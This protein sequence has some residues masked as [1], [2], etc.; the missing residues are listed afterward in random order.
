MEYDPLPLRV[1]MFLVHKVPT[2]RTAPGGTWVADPGFDPTNREAR[3]PE[4][5]AIH[6]GAG[7]EPEVVRLRHSLKP[8]NA[9]TGFIDTAAAFA[10]LPPQEQRALEKLQVWYDPIRFL[11]SHHSG[12]A[13]YTTV[14]RA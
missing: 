10:A 2:A 12:A 9:E 13:G 14:P 7:H 3:R 4:E 5:P 1:S 8:L 6:S 11:H